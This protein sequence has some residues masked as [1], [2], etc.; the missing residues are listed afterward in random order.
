[1]L[2]V[3]KGALWT[4]ARQ[5]GLELKARQGNDEVRSRAIEI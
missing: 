4:E 1:M 2:A 3:E 5:Q